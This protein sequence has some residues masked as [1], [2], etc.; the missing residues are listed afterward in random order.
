MNLTHPA[1]AADGAEMFAAFYSLR[2]N[3]FGPAD[4][5]FIY[6]SVS[7][8]KALASLHYGIERGNAIQLLLADAGL[9]KT[10]LLRHLQARLQANARVI[11]LAAADCKTSELLANPAGPEK[12]NQPALSTDAASAGNHASANSADGETGRLIVLID[13]AQDLG[14]AELAG[15]FALATAESSGPFNTHII[16]AGRPRL[17]EKLRKSHPA[18]IIREVP[19]AP[20][21]PAETTEY[22]NHRLRLAAGGPSALFTPAAYATIAA[23]SGGVPSIINTI[24]M[25]AL[26]A[27]A[28]R[29]LPQ[30]DTAIL[31]R[32]EAD[33]GQRFV[34]APFN[35]EA[36][37]TWPLPGRYLPKWPW[38]ALALALVIAAAAGLWI[39]NQA[40]LH[41]TAGDSVNQANFSGQ[42]NSSSKSGFAGSSGPL[43]KAVPPQPSNGT[44]ANPL[45]MRGAANASPP[46][47]ATAPSATPRYQAV[48]A[49]PVGNSSELSPPPH[50]AASPASASGRVVT[51]VP[52]GPSQSIAPVM[53]PSSGLDSHSP[54]AA[55]HPYAASS[56]PAPPPDPHRARIFA[57]VG[58]DYMRLHK[59]RQAIDFYQD[60]AAL[61]PGDEQ[62]KKK[63]AEARIGALTQ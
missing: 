33:D 25:R 4:P 2:E 46:G 19:I 44:Q 58:D 22:I 52:S 26:A 13:D 3:P 10:T 15:L 23:Q 51:P 42:A 36:P 56:N 24:S 32:N 31:D 39:E 59:Y 5:R 45:I 18:N 41:P 35:T 12:N 54:P 29:R 55:S 1:S 53:A 49:V 28:E 57:E 50:S 6:L 60:A 30:I 34:M 63:L 37:A 21:G 47:S 43:A 40:S 7:H 16:L 8:R 20:M 17:A 61:A 11:L 14:D 38:L 62:I 48:A 9:G 27:G